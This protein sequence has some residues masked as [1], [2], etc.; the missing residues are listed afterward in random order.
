MPAPLH[1]TQATMH[2]AI[3]DAFHRG[4]SLTWD[5]RKSGEAKY[6]GG[7]GMKVAAKGAVSEETQTEMCTPAPNVGY[8]QCP[9]KR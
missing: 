6:G 8:E 7:C 9:V 1:T 5:M 4:F 3:M 2:P